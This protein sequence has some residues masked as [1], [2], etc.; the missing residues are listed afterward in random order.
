VRVS[1]AC[2][3]ASVGEDVCICIYQLVCA[4]MNVCECECVLVRLCGRVQVHRNHL[5]MIAH[6][7]VGR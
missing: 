7:Q 6:V 5:H 4:C 2:A 3:R 1:I